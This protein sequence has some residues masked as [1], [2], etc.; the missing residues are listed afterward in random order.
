M[1][2]GQGQWLRSPLNERLGVCCL[3]RVFRVKSSLVKYLSS[4]MWSFF[5]SAYLVSTVSHDLFNYKG[6]N[7]QKGKQNNG[8]STS[9]GSALGSTSTKL[10]KPARTLS[11][12]SL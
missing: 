6:C 11:P 9:P 2:S 12:T 1:K 10:G 5:S 4:R 3:C 8:N 7:T